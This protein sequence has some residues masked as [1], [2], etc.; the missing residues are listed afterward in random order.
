[1]ATAP[2]AP[3]CSAEEMLRA[4]N[5]YAVA[6]DLEIWKAQQQA[7]FRMQLRAAKEKLEKRILSELTNRGK[8]QMDELENAHHELESMAKH[9]QNT[10]DELQRRSLQLDAREAAFEARRVRVA[11]QHEGHL[12][13]VEQRSQQVVEE[14]T[15]TRDVLSVLVREK[16]MIIAQ[17]QDRLRAAEGRYDELQRRTAAMLA[18][19]GTDSSRAAEQQQLETTRATVRQLEMRL[20]DQ[21]HRMSLDDREREDLRQRLHRSEA[22]L[23]EV[24]KQYN[25]LRRQWHNRQQETLRSER[26]KLEEERNRLQA[27]QHRH[28]GRQDGLHY[29]IQSLRDGVTARL[30]QQAVVKSSSTARGTGR[31]VLAEQPAPRQRPPQR[32]SAAEKPDNS[33]ERHEFSRT[34]VT[35]IPPEDRKCND[36]VAIALP[37]PDMEPSIEETSCHSEPERRRSGTLPPLAPSLVHEEQ[38]NMALA[39][40]P[41]TSTPSVLPG[42]AAEAALSSCGGSARSEVETFLQHLRFNRQKLLDTGV[43]TE[44]HP[45]VQ[46]MSNKVELYE[47]YLAK[48]AA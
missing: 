8:V 19:E 36:S 5:E 1:M 43:Y 47:E 35:V 15:A 26:E 42:E 12:S 10:G 20:A 18:A 27:S 31:Y 28:S 24:T 32:Q 33:V 13:R 48:M 11:E 45:V 44:E 9:L 41:F 23:D 25:V 4:T 21:S 3:E 7:R 6:F 29:M 2:H 30:D 14:V 16:E 40:A 37:P 39:Q 34:A 38:S 17:L 22:Q 46:E